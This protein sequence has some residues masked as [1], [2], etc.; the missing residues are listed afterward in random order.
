MGEARNKVSRECRGTR[1][2]ES[3]I[4]SLR[5]AARD[6]PS[7]RV[8]IDMTGPVLSCGLDENVG[9]DITTI[10]VETQMADMGGGGHRSVNL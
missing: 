8:D 5:V 2:A 1:G 6:L 10:K 4:L 7:V 3:V 9:I